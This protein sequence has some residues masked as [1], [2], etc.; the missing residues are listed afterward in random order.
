[1]LNP[2]HAPKVVKKASLQVGVFYTCVGVICYLG[3]GEDLLN[4][5]PIEKMLE[6]GMPYTV[7]AS[8]ISILFSAKAVCAYPLLFRP[9]M[10]EIETAIASDELP[11][12]ELRLPWALK[13]QGRLKL[14]VRGVLVTSTLAA[15]FLRQVNSGSS[16]KSWVEWCA[17]LI[18]IF[19]QVFAPALFVVRSLFVHKQNLRKRSAGNHGGAGRR[20]TR[21]A[22]RSLTPLSHLPTLNYLGGRVRSHFV[23]S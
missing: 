18:F 14:A 9:F 6:L 1:M 12:V 15:L 19:V 8:L 2:H 13:W 11:C 22:G 23:I 4:Q 3:W 20:T 21:S 16:L 10:R 17:F 7:M 5:S